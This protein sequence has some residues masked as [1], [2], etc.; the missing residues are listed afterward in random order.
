VGSVSGIGSRGLR[1]PAIVP[2]ATLQAAVA[3]LLPAQVMPPPPPPPPP[4]LVAVPLP[5]KMA[6]IG[7]AGWVDLHTHPMIQLAFGGKL[8]HGGV[9][10]RS[11]LP[12]NSL[13]QPWQPAGSIFEALGNDRPSHGGWD[14]NF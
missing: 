10:E 3:S 7:L 11:I 8:I 2:D 13:C 4:T 6:Y 5:M 12:S 14:I 9:D 1:G